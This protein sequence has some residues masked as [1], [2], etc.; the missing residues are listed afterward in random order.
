MQSHISRGRSASS[1]YLVSRPGDPLTRAATIDFSRLARLPLVL[2]RRPA[3]W[4]AVLDE[5]ARSKGFT[6]QAEVEADS[7]RVQRELVAQGHRLYSLLGSFSIAEDV[8][9]GRLAAARVVN[10]DLRRHVTL[11]L[12]RHGPL[13]PASKVVS[14]LIRELVQAWGHQLHEPGHPLQALA[15]RY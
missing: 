14:R 9:A 13:T 15:P 4:R 7:L 6:L 8:A 3:H 10:P 11:A 1:T 5:A 12:P 2:P